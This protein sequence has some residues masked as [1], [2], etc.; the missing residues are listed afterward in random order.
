MTNFFGGGGRKTAPTPPATQLRVQTAVAGTPIPIGWGTN[1]IAPNLIYYN[2]FLATEVQQ[3]S[4]GGKGSGSG[5]GGKGGGGGTQTN[6]SATV[7]CGLCEGPILGVGT[8]VGSTAAVSGNV[9]GS[10]NNNLFFNGFNNPITQ[11]TIKTLISQILTSTTTSPIGNGVWVSG[12]I[13]SLAAL[14]FALL[15]GFLEPS[16]TTLDANPRDI[17]VDFL[18][19]NKYGLQFPSSRIGD[20]NLVTLYNYCQS[21]GIWMSPI[22][23]AQKDANSFMQDIL[24]G[25]V[26]EA[27]WSNG[28]LK[29]VPY[30]DSPVSGHGASFT[31]NLSPIYDLTDDDFQAGG[32]TSYSSPV[33]VTIKAV[34]DIYNNVKVQYLDR[35]FNYAGAA[36]S[37]PDY[38]PTVVEVKDDALIQQYTL[39]ARDTKQLDLF[40]YGPAAQQCALLQL[41]REQ[42]ITTY[43]FSLGANFVLLEPM[44]L[45]TLTDVAL[46]LSRKLVR[47]K[48]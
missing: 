7:V 44:D 6:Y 19:N 23:S 13:S 17:I 20:T 1:R 45:V 38:N 35:N 31:P 5:G 39:R 30:Y 22:L 10:Q 14:N 28:Q 34:A 11:A 27:V 4:G 41:G 46:G 29:V 48:E 32:N 47:I 33:I 9:F 36:G 25:C 24:Y 3:S 8:Q 2:D 42:V 21:V 15:F 37:T 12:N 43:Q 40:C 26:A 16:N 18:T